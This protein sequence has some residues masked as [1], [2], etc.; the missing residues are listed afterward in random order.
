ML[1]LTRHELYEG[2]CR[3]IESSDIGT[4]LYEGNK[5][6]IRQ[7]WLVEW[8]DIRDIRDFLSPGDRITQ[9]TLAGKRT[10]RHIHFLANRDED[11]HRFPTLVRKESDFNMN[12]D[13]GEIF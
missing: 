3:L 12:D 13:F 2:W 4:T 11:R 5:L 9:R 1:L 7:R 6:L 10:H 8:L